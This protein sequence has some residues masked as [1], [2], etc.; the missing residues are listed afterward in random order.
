MLRMTEIIWLSEMEEYQGAS[1][2]SYALLYLD[3]S[4]AL[5]LVHVGLVLFLSS[6]ARVKIED[7]M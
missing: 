1:K 2:A 6:L 4:E 7:T 3:L 5:Y